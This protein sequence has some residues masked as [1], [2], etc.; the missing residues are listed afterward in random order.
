MPETMD[1]EGWRVANVA[2]GHPSSGIAP[3][4]IE[5]ECW[6][7]TDITSGHTGSHSAF[8]IDEAVLSSKL[9]GL[10]PAYRAKPPRALPL[11]MVESGQETRTIVGTSTLDSVDTDAQHL[12]STVQEDSSATGS[13]SSR[14]AGSWAQLFRDAPRPYA[15]SSNGA[16]ASAGGL[17]AARHDPAGRAQPSG[18][19]RRAHSEGPRTGRPRAETSVE[20]RSAGA[21]VCSSRIPRPCKFMWQCRN[22]AS[23][24]YCHDD[25]AH[26]HRKWQTGRG[27]V[28][29]GH[30]AAGGGGRGVAERSVRSGA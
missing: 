3:E 11:R 13:R 24:S 5:E 29:A 2:V 16:G 21:H 22:V 8:W 6:H 20:R 26:C 1:A 10:L 14:R 28:L 7:V 4:A 18:E 27:A 23:C 17:A 25:A 19:Q 12:H 30:D 9:R 15:P